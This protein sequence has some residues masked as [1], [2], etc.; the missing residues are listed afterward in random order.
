[1]RAVAPRRWAISSLIGVVL[2]VA[3]GGSARAQD[4]AGDVR[5]TATVDGRALD[6][7]DANEALRLGEQEVVV[8]LSVDNAGDEELFVRSV[9]LDGEVM[10][11]TFFAFETR[12]DLV[13]APGETGER[14]F[15]FEL[16]DLGKQA[17][18]LLPAQLALLDGDR[19]VVASQSFP[20]DVRGSP[21]SIYGVFALLVGAITALL[22]VTAVVSLAAH[23]LSPNRWR[24]GV[25]FG[26]AGL[27]LGLTLTFTLSTLRVLVPSASRWVSLVAICGAVLFVIGFRTPNP[28]VGDE[29][30]D[31]D[32]AVP[33][34]YEGIPT[35]AAAAPA[36]VPAPADGD[37]GDERRPVP[38]NAKSTIQHADRPPPPLHP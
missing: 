27:G 32:D 5:F 2:T 31:D 18:G 6:D 10:A 7:V 22:I 11:L 20:A 15:T 38:T 9:R 29:E 19:A 1:M 12:V 4:D 14:E 17:N 8:S 35:P 25:R 13:V 36:P 28:D 34:G 30:D 23:R 37:G 21:L 16:I 33:D 3:L 26:T 24:R